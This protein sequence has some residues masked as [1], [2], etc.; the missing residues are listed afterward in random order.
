MRIGVI[1]IGM[2]GTAVYKAFSSKIDTIGFDIKGEFCLPENLHTIQNC[3][4]LCFICVPTPT[5]NFMQ[6]LSALENV[7]MSLVGYHGVVVIKCTVLP[8]TCEKLSKRYNLKIVH[9]P[10]FLTE[11][12]AYLDFMNQKAVICSG[13]EDHLSLVKLAYQ[14]ALPEAT[15]IGYEKFAVTELAKYMRNVYLAMK[16]TF[17][18]EIDQLCNQLNIEYD[19][20]RGAFLS[21][22]GIEEG[23]TL[24]PGPD[25]KLGYGGACFPKDVRALAAYCY[26]QGTVSD[27][28]KAI[29]VS[30]NHI[31]PHDNFC[32]ELKK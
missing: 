6:D 26:Q 23:H 29:D 2:V 20:V 4:D 7:L 30:N 15:F 8:G 11:R 25:G 28:I 21:Q 12:N 3:T 16:V 13:K 9:N 18:N 10:E 5:I 19:F 32:K 1:G 31:R 24:V 14:I 27:V 22:G 17:C